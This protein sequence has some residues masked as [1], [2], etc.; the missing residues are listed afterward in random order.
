MR[1]TALFFVFLLACLA[2]AAWLSQP[3]MATGWLAL[4]P[5]RVMSRLAQLCIL[6]GVW[7]LLLWLHLSDRDSLGYAIPG[8][9]LRRSVG[10]GWIVGVAILLALVLMLL[11]LGIRVPDPQPPAWSSV[12]SRAVQALVG[13]L[14][15]GLLEETF[16]RGALYSAVRRTSG[17][18][19]AMIWSALL[20]ASVHFMKPGALPE[21]MAFDAAGALWMFTHALT[22][23]FQWSNLDSLVALLCVGVFLAAVRER[24]GHLGWCIGLHAGWVFVIQMG[25]TLTD[26]DDASNFAFLVGDYDGTIGWL[27]AAWIGLLTLLYWLLSGRRSG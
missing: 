16:F 8:A 10:L 17:V 7:P 12:L 27:A 6:L 22:D 5:H 9:T 15:I 19:A 4:E 25:R 3:L 24:T 14:L 1:V 23:L 20:Y 21:G 18:G 11:G 2:L 26:G 13:G